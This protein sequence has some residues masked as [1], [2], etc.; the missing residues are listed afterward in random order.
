M[1]YAF[2][3]LVLLGLCIGLLPDEEDG[4]GFDE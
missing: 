1:I 2:L 3:A 4:G